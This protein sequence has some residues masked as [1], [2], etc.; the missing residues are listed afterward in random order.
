MSLAFQGFV[1]SSMLLATVQELISTAT[2][3]Y[4]VISNVG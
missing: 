4:C 2:A 1:V 3:E